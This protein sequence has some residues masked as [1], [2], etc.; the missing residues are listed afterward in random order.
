MNGRFGIGTE[1]CEISTSQYFCLTNFKCKYLQLIN[2]L[3]VIVMC[4]GTSKI[5][6]KVKLI[7]F[8]KKKNLKHIYVNEFS[9]GNEKQNNFK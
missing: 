9:R 3:Y 2:C 4:V 5:T 8:L 7:V 6:K 1:R